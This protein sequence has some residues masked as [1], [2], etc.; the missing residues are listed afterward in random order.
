MPGIPQSAAGYL[1]IPK[2]TLT[3]TTNPNFKN[4]EQQIVSPIKIINKRIVNTSTLHNVSNN[5]P[6]SSINLNSTYADAV[7]L[8]LK[9]P[10]KHSVSNSLTTQILLQ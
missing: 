10:I 4:I 1:Q 7:F 2:W 3:I 5:N 8:Q 6:F 9:N